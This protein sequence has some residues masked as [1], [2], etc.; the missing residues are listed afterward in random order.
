MNMW[1][2]LGGGAALLLLMGAKGG[3]GGGNGKT[4]LGYQVVVRGPAHLIPYGGGYVAGSRA[5][6]E[7]MAA[8]VRAPLEVVGI[9]QLPVQDLNYWVRES[10][11]DLG[12]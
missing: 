11:K 9:R 4:T 7:Q 8:A 3:G 5:E 2:L 10:R 6:A 1:W 12:L